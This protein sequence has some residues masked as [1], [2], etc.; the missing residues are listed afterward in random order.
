MANI[1]VELLRRMVV[2]LDVQSQA[3]QHLTQAHLN[4]TKS[5]QRVI[6][7]SENILQMYDDFSTIQKQILEGQRILMERIENLT[8]IIDQLQQQQSPSYLIPGMEH[9]TTP[10]PV[11]GLLDVYFDDLKAL[12]HRVQY[13]ETLHGVKP[14]DPK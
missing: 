2:Q 6:D 13:L 10:D 1:L 4:L 3:I 5:Q 9:A 14:E 11:Y 8:A 7:R 12:K